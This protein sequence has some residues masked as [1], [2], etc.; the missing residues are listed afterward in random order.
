MTAILYS[1]RRCPYAMRARMALI[2]SG[3]PVELR[4]VVLRDKPPAMLSLSPKGTVPVLALPDGAV[5]DESLDIMRWALRLRDPEGWL[6]GDDAALIATNDGPFKQH[7]D[8]YKYAT[9]YGSD[10]LVHRAGAMEVLGELEARL[11]AS[12][13]LCGAHRTL[14]DIAI[15]PFVR[16]FAGTEP[17]WFEAQPLPRVQAW[18]RALVA[19][20]LFARAM[21]RKPAWQPGD[22]AVFL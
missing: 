5:I 22:A 20:E 14:A 6:D 19:S 9:R 8:R 7:L 11:V 18:L 10:P 12:D 3:Q 2:A 1:F 16:Q 4:E 13:Y 21:V 17:A 15:F